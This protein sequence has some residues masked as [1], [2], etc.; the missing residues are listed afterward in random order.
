MGDHEPDVEYVP[1][2]I[3]CWKHV[4]YDDDTQTWQHI[5]PA[6]AKSAPPAM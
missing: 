1:I 3:V 5:I 4:D 6:N 2:C